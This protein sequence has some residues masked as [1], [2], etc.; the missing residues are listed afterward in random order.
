MAQKKDTA[1]ISTYHQ[2][3][4]IMGSV[5]TSYVQVDDG[6]N[7]YTP[8]YPLTTGIGLAIK[9]TIVSLDAGY[10]FIPL[11]NKNVYGRSKMTDFQI[12]RYGNNAIVDLYFQNYKG[13]YSE[14]K[15]GIVDH[16]LP[17]MRVTQIGAEYSYLLNGKQFSSKAAFDLNEIQ[18]KSAGSWLLGGG[19]YYSLIKGL[20]SEENNGDQLENIQ[21]GINAGY[22]YS[23]VLSEHW[24][25]TAMAKGG[26]NFGNTPENI[27]KGKVE[28]FPT[29]YAR[30]AGNYHKNDWGLSLSILIGSKPVSPLN[31]STVSMTTLSMQMAYVKHIDYLFRKKHHNK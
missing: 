3:F 28:I 27:S 14:K 26:V 15:I 5:S 29:A 8:N 10:G 11:K 12:H 4:R 18:K 22:V 21:L 25:L 17:D 19:A 24:M 23:Y 20:Q 31:G 13:F 16:I 30:F 6:T 1:Y 9:N 7:H 2:K